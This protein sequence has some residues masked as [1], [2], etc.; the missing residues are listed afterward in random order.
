MRSL[1]RHAFE[2]FGPAR[3]CFACHSLGGFSALAAV[4]DILPNSSLIDIA[5]YH[6]LTIKHAV[7]HDEQGR[8]NYA[9][10]AV[11]FS[12]VGKT[13]DDAALREIVNTIS[14]GRDCVLETVNFNVEVRQQIFMSLR[15]Y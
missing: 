8:S 4:S 13:F 10:C 15:S 2:K 9:M 14:N 5:F 3:R 7:E 6:S 1:R 12:H 11:N